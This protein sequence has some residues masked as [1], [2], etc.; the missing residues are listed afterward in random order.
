MR[1]HRS[2]LVS[3][4]LGGLVSSMAGVIPAASAAS[5][6]MRTAYVLAGDHPGTAAVTITKATTLVPMFSVPSAAS[7]YV[8]MEILRSDRR[9]GAVSFALVFSDGDSFFG[10]LSSTSISGGAQL[11]PGQTP[12]AVKTDPVTLTPGRY[13]FVLLTHAPAVMSFLSASPRPVHPVN[14]RATGAM[15]GDENSSTFLGSPAAGYAFHQLPLRVPNGSHGVVLVA[16]D[17]WSGNRSVDYFNNCLSYGPSPIPC[18]SP[19]D[20]EGTVREFY[21]ET[22]PTT[23]S[24]Q[25]GGV[26]FHTESAPKPGASMATFYSAKSGTVAYQ[27]LVALAFP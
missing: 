22:T 18:P 5:T 16:D 19:L 6:V 15:V 23:E 27:E 9:S 10:K 25:H 1:L 12:Q 14:L 26:G 7:G 13:I 4:V 20:A 17:R 3:L 11:E 8:G 21:A 2:A 24:G